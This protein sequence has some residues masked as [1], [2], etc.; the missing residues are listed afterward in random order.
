[1]GDARTAS[2]PETWDQ[3]RE[4]DGAQRENLHRLLWLASLW[5]FPSEDQYARLFW[6]RPRLI[7]GAGRAERRASARGRDVVKQ[8]Q[9]RSRDL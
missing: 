5:V 1:M 9:L 3:R 7:S 8:T 6:D 4:I 2:S